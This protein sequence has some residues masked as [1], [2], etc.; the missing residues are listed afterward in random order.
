MGVSTSSLK[1]GEN[2]FGDDW[3]KYYSEISGTEIPRDAMVR[4]HAH[5]KAQ[6]KGGNAAG[7]LNREILRE[8]NINPELSRHNLTW[9]P[10]V[11][12]QHGVA[13]QTELLKM[14]I[15]VRG[16]RDGVIDVLRQWDD[17]SRSR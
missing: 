6:K 10:N 11:T 9:A 8:V 12:G 17:I 16:N 15:E 4:P 3:A 5:H 2:I 14:L 13:P 7:A 1:K